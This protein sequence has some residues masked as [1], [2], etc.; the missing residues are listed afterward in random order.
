MNNTFA[1]LR[2]GRFVP[3]G[4][5]SVGLSLLVALTA[6]AELAVKDGQ[7]VAFLGDSITEGGWGNPAGYVRLVVA[8]LAANGIKVTPVPAGISGHKS[9]QMLERLR[10]D[11]LDK[12]PD[13]MT[14]SC[15]VNDVWHGAN[16]V[17]LEAYR[18]NIVAI[19]EQCQAAGVQVLI[20]TATVIGEELDNDNNRKL[21]PY[22]E[23]LRSLAKERNCRLAD[24]NAMFQEA[25]KAS[26]RPGRAFTS[27][28][29]HMNSAGDQ[30][31][32]RG[33]LQAFGLSEAQLNQAR[34]GWRDIPGSAVL[35]ASY[36][37][38]KGKMLTVACR[39]TLRQRQEVE[40]LALKEGK[41]LEGWID[42]ALAE[43]AK[44]L[45]T[46]TGPYQSFEEMFRLRKE[47]EAQTVLEQRLSKRLAEMLKK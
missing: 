7:K 40:S 30:L 4:L 45:L 24:L 42:Q 2:S 17:P 26:G 36:A 33:V 35:R 14:L 12:K 37:A 47:K 32:A 9:N 22:N 11:V 16:G 3:G 1:C 15:G 21:A 39:T 41:S 46:P 44:K 6:A 23:F 38:G 34:E 10:R 18:T 8:G 31:M 19:L 29:V 28:G 27:D 43:E 25:I 20:L 13:W 5:V